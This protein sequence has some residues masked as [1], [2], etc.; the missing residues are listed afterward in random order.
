MEKY[1][2]TIIELLTLEDFLEIEFKVLRGSKRI[3]Q[4]ILKILTFKRDLQLKD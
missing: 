4:K 3:I 1:K 2:F